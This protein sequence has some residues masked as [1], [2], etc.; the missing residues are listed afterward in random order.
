MARITKANF[1]KAA[2]NSSGNQTRIAEQMEVTRS[3]INHFLKRNPDMREL[4]E[5]EADRLIDVC[6]DNIDFQIM[7]NKDVAL[8]QWKLLNSKGGKARGY[9]PKQEIESIG[10][11]PVTITLIEKSVKE[12]K[13]AKSVKRDTV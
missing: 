2:V 5:E 9:G 4:L 3:A 1:K 11:A 13:D 10:N 6:E 7:Q 12:I 8:A